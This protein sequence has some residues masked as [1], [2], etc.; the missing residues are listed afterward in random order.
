MNATEQY[1]FI[2]KHLKTMQVVIDDNGEVTL[3]LKRK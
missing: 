2:E 1:Q 3:E